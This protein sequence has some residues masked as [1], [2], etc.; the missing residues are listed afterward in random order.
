MFETVTYAF[1]QSDLMGK[2]I[3]IGLL[4]TSVYV[5]CLMICKAFDMYEINKSCRQFRKAFDKGRTSPLAISQ[6]V[7]NYSGPLPELCR[8]ALAELQMILHLSPADQ[9]ILT[10]HRILTR[11]L[12]D[13]EIE[14]IRSSMNRAVSVQIQYLEDKL[15]VLGSI[16][17]LSPMAGL[18]GTVWGVMA[19]FIGIAKAGR[20]ELMAI[21]PGISGALLTTVAGLL[22]AMPSLIGNNLIIAQ[23]QDIISNMD[24]FVEEFISSLRLEETKIP[25]LQSATTAPAGS[26]SSQGEN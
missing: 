17:A 18:F 3:V 5:W 21:A 14:K 12:T 20:P 13:D 23:M 10:R 2:L 24:T 11:K 6:D 7:E 15:T 4:I 25:E 1:L 22:V 16:V 19:T 9:L 8:V 26:S